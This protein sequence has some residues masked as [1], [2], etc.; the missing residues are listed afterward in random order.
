MEQLRRYAVLGLAGF[1]LYQA[2]IRFIRAL[3]DIT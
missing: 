2:G 3:D 1:A